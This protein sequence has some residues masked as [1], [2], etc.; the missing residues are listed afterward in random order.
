GSSMGGM[1][2]FEMAQQLRAQGGQVLQVALLDTPGP[3]Q[4][5]RRPADD[6][7]ILSYLSGGRTPAARLRRLPADRQLAAF[8]AAAEAAARGEVNFDLA[9]ARRLLAVF[10]QH[11][12]AMRAYAP[13][14]YPGRLAFFRAGSRRAG[15]PRHPERP[16][17]DFAADGIEIHH[18]PGNH[19]TMHHPPHLE[20]LAARLDRCL[21]AASGGA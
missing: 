6:A 21:R 5:P 15:D 4:M 10:K 9:I 20:T 18:V 3:G 16:W 8:I 17:I 12:A 13:R 1:I 7:A 14:R 2:A 11:M 19:I